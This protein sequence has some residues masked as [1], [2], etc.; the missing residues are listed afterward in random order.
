MFQCVAG[1]AKSIP[2][3]LYSKLRFIVNVH[4]IVTEMNLQLFLPSQI[5]HRLTFE[6]RVQYKFI[7]IATLVLLYTTKLIKSILF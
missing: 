7:C 3:S 2:A 1:E 5:I 4:I 6:L